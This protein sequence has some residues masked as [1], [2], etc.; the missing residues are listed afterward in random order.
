MQLH[1]E[2]TY[3]TPNSIA[4][5]PITTGGRRGD[6]NLVPSVH[7]LCF[8]ICG[9]TCMAILMPMAGV[10]FKEW[11]EMSFS[12]QSP[13]QEINMALSLWIHT[14]LI[15][16]LEVLPA[17]DQTTM[18][19]ACLLVEQIIIWHGVR[20]LLSDCGIAFLSLL[21]KDVCHAMST[22]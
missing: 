16:R 6:H 14:K 13:E 22:H 12:F 3:T 9:Q 15:K 7:D 4:S 10:F 19:F 5:F 8:R 20:E 21:M 11:G 2:H 17:L 1:L 18:T